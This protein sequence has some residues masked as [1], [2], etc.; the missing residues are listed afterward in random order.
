[1]RLYIAAIAPA[2]IVLGQIK[3]LKYLVPF[4]ALANVSIMIG[5]AITLWYIFS[6]IKPITD[7]TK[8]VKSPH[9]IPFFFSTVIFAIEGIG[10]VSFIII[11][12]IIFV[13]EC[14]KICFFF[15]VS[16]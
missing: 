8:L 15:F 2:L 16:R 12:I 11:I 14:I 3:N 4:S 13:N 5:F 1:M 7:E 10:V 9:E 6:D